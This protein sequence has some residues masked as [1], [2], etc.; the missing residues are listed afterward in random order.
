MIMK[1]LP[2]SHVVL[3]SFLFGNRVD[4][5]NDLHRTLAAFV[6]GSLVYTAKQ[7]VAHLGYELLVC[8]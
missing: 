7:N 1:W 4:S 2:K 5:M 6:L 8:G 3:V